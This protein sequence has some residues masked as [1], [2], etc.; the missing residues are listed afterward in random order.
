MLPGPQARGRLKS[1]EELRGAVINV[2]ATARIS[3]TANVTR[4]DRIGLPCWQAIRP[5]G[6][7]LSVHQGKGLTDDDAKLGAVLEALEA[8][9]GEHYAAPVSRCGFRDLPDAIRPPALSDFAKDDRI[10][11][12]PGKPIDWVIETDWHGRQV[13]VPFACV[14]MDFTHSLDTG[15]DRSSNGI[16]VGSTRDEAISSALL[17]LIERDAITA[18]KAGSMIDRMGDQID[19]ESVRLPWLD[20]WLDR[21]RAAETYLRCY[22]VSSLTGTPVIASELGD[23]GKSAAPY[24]AVHGHSAHPDPEIALFRA[25]AEAVQG[26]SAYIAGSRDDLPPSEY[27]ASVDGLKVAFAMPLPDGMAG[28]DFQTIQRGPETVGD[29][30]RAIEDKGLGPIVVID[31]G[32]VGP[33]HVVRAI[34]CGMAARNRQRR[35]PA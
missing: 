3:R 15:L 23:V 24:R 9:C 8:H 26:R 32:Q 21:L 33:F 18:W 31:L 6:R 2:T 20:F 16:A 29:M 19:F 4:L 22:S 14:S 30:I 5:M 1:A 13:A 35:C 10:A 34:A 17:E 11:L 7:S 12:D 28:T 25:M 27:S